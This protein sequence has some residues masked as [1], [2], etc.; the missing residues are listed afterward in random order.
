MFLQQYSDSIYSFLSLLFWF[1]SARNTARSC[2][3]QSPSYI[4]PSR[5]SLSLRLCSLRLCLAAVAGWSVAPV[6]RSSATI[7]F[8]SK[9]S[10]SSSISSWRLYDAS[11]TTASFS[12][13]FFLHC[14]LDGRKQLSN[15]IS[16]SNQ[17]SSFTCVFSCP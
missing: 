15:L 12:S 11:S 4:A 3:V 10:D 9:Q 16:I 8:I 14:H 7:I 2:V 1:D 17:D 5:R 6:S 13:S